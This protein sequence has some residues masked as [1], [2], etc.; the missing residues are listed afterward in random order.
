MLHSKDNKPTETDANRSSVD[1][2]KKLIEFLSLLPNSNMKELNVYRSY[3]KQLVLFLSERSEGLELMTLANYLPFNYFIAENIYRSFHCHHHSRSYLKRDDFV[4]GMIKLC[5]GTFSQ[6]LNL[7]FDILDF[8]CDGIVLIED[9][10]IIFSH[11]Y[12]LSNNTNLK[13]AHSLIDAFFQNKKSLSKDSFIQRTKNQNSDL[14]FL[15]IY[16]INYHTPIDE[17]SI[18]YYATHIYR[19]DLIKD[20]EKID[21]PVL[22]STD[23][24]ITNEESDDNVIGISMPS[25]MLYDFLNN[26]F[27]CSYSIDSELNDLDNFEENIKN[28]INESL[29]KSNCIK[30]PRLIKQRKMVSCCGLVHQIELEHVNVKSHDDIAGSKPSLSSTNLKTS[31]SHLANISFDNLYDFYTNSNDKQY[32]QHKLEIVGNDLYTYKVVSESQLKFQQIFPLTQ[33]YLVIDENKKDSMGKVAVHLIS[34][35]CNKL[36]DSLIYFDSISIV[37]QLQRVIEAK[38]KYRRIEDDYEFLSVIGKG[39][40]GTVLEAEKKSSKKHYAVKVILKNYDTDWEIEQLKIETDISRFLMQFPYKGIVKTIDIYETYD[41]LYIVQEYIRNGN[42]NTLILE[43]HHCKLP[44]SLAYEIMQQLIDSISYLKSFGIVHRD[45]KTENILIQIKNSKH[46]HTHK[47]IQTK[48][49]DFG[50]SAVIGKEEKLTEKLGTLCYLPP[51]MLSSKPYDFKIDIWTLGVICYCLLY[52]KHPFIQENMAHTIDTIHHKIII[53]PEIRHDNEKERAM[54][55]LIE[56][57]LQRDIMFRP[58]ID[59]I[60]KQFRNNSN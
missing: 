47:I 9:V 51:E 10:K 36:K 29:A 11:L 3:F 46:N 60:A 31:S 21:E 41:T 7:L 58:S 43:K 22:H 4:K 25:D 14:F 26:N 2:F 28:V 55:K 38:T 12:S 53:L 5:Y 45:L 59:S 57:C 39:S 32:V 54:R 40:F 37:N 15:F 27:N 1:N 18:D 35:I 34:T 44:I 19:K 6:R 33:L 16:L 49:I 48:I 52:G 24:P 13:D 17:L 50:L 42:L 30:E 23:R 8:N 20:F 56:E